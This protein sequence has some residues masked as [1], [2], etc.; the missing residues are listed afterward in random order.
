[1]NR[2]QDGQPREINALAI[3][4]GDEYPATQSTTRRTFPGE[5]IGALVPEAPWLFAVLE[6]IMSPSSEITF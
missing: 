5:A 1:M 2:T 4:F 6:A 3:D